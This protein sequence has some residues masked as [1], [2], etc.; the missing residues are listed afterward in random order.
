MVCVLKIIFQ[1]YATINYITK[2]LFFLNNYNSS[3]S[4]ISS[5]AN[6]FCC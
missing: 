5:P 2:Y 4:L 3:E 1:N 6:C